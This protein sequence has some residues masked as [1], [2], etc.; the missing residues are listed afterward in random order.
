MHEMFVSTHTSCIGLTVARSN[1]TRYCCCLPAIDMQILEV[2]FTS[3]HTR[4]YSAELLRVCS[5][6]AENCSEGANGK[7]SS[8]SSTTTSTAA[9]G[10]AAA[11]QQHC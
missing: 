7:V 2:S 6:S 11:H 4:K 10:A 8:S 9:A 5:P 3:G 1:N